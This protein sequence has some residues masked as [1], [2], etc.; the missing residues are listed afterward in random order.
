M[1]LKHITGPKAKVSAI[2]GLRALR[3][4]IAKEIGTGRITE[5][6]LQRKNISQ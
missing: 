2:S 6:G 3:Q 5:L 4:L 1:C